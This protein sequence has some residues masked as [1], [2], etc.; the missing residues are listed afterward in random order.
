M[1]SGGGADKSLL[2]TDSDVIETVGQAWGVATAFG[3]MAPLAKTASQLLQLQCR[4]PGDEGVFPVGMRGIARWSL[5]PEHWGA[6]RHTDLA[7]QLLLSLLWWLLPVPA[8][9]A[10]GGGR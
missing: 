4:L 10:R 2:P 7:E 8:C 1:P 3:E 6:S 5:S 9:G